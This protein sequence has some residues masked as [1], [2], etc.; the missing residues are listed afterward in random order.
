MA[1]TSARSKASSLRP[2]MTDCGWNVRAKQRFVGSAGQD[3][4]MLAT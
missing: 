2:A 3:G 4:R 1:G